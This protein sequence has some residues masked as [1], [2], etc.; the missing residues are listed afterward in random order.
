MSLIGEGLI[1]EYKVWRINKHQVRDITLRHDLHALSK[2]FGYAIKQRWSRENP[3]RKVDIPS[4]AGA[5]RIHVLT[6][7][8]RR[9]TLLE[10]SPIA[11]CTTLD[12]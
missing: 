7:R 5:V 8:K 1:E 3:V 11:I 12:D 10:R 6:P 9:C 4:D 2:F